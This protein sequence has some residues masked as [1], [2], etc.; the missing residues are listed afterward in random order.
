M[1][2][3]RRSAA[4]LGVLTAATVALAAQQAP[5]TPPPQQQ[6]PTFRSGVPPLAVPASVFD[7]DGEVVSTLTRDDFMVFDDGRRQELTNFESGQQPI[8]AL[9]L[10]D[11]SASM[12]ARLDLAKLAAGEFVG[13]VGA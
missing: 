12:I 4:L 6:A 7:R 10:L 11:T 8:T 9:V 1:H 2:G 13:R 3:P 5:P